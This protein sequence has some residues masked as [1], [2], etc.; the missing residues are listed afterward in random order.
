MW[1]NKHSE[2]ILLSCDKKNIKD[3]KISHILDLLQIE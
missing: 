1:L 2:T 3:I